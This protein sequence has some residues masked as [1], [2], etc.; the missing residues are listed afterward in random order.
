MGVCLVPDIFQTQMRLQFC[1]S[2]SEQFSHRYIWLIRG[3]LIQGL[4]GYEET[5]IGW[6][7]TQD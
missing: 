3:A 2:L 7:H 1:K 6:D 4:G 5:P